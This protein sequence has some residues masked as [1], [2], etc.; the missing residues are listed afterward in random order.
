MRKTYSIATTAPKGEGELSLLLAVVPDGGDIKAAV[1]REIS[2]ANIAPEDGTSLEYKVETG[3]ILTD[4]LADGEQAVWE[5]DWNL[6]WLNDE[7]DVPFGY[8]VR[9]PEAAQ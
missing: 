9:R 4:D 8:A 1:A 5:S 2:T 3:L 6:G 7:N